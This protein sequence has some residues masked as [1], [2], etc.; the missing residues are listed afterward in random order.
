MGWAQGPT[1]FT[2]LLANASG[3]KTW[4]NS[5]L[6]G[7]N[8]KKGDYLDFGSVTARNGGR[9]WMRSYW[10]I[11]LQI[12]IGVDSLEQCRSNY[13]GN[14][15][16]RITLGMVRFHTIRVVSCLSYLVERWGIKGVFGLA[17]QPA[18]H[19]NLKNIFAEIFFNVS[20][21]FWCTGVKNYF[22]KIKRK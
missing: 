16:A 18:F 2:L 7:A 8:E 6:N 9:C 22:W 11:W 5:R 21:F 1:H 14:Q 17:V 4:I 19:Q 10:K 15:P 3:N 20:R 12:L 13:R